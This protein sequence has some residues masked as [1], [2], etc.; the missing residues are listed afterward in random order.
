MKDY[1]RAFLQASADNDILTFRS[2]GFVLKSGRV[3]PYFFNAGLFNN[4]A[5]L[6]LISTAYASSLVDPDY[7]FEF[8]VLFGPAYKGIPLAVATC[9]ALSKERPNVE[10]SFNRKEVK[11]HGEGGM[12][13][14]GR[15]RGKR[16]VIIDDVI[17]SGKAIR[18][19]IKIIDKE[20]GILTGIL[21]AVDR[22]EQT[23]DSGL[24]AIESL[25]IEF[26]IKVQAI[27]T[28]R[29]II[30]FVRSAL[31]ETM[32]QQLESYRAKYGAIEHPS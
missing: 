19:A 15:L 12:I 27:I 4:G 13:V 7:S 30:E 29:D 6:S 16:V 28:L 17:T 3:S 18:E 24:S 26:A 8:D 31:G 11:D 22:Q 23:Q 21:V 32:V 14:G 9:Q 5:L 2:D 10:Y 1:Q 20:G 25:S